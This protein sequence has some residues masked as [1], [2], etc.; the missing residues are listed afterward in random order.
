[1]KKKS[2]VLHLRK[3]KV[4][5]FHSIYGGATSPCNSPSQGTTD[6]DTNP[7]SMA[8]KG[9]SGSGKNDEPQNTDTE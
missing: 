6:L 2:I 1:M 8:I 4:A 7:T 9:C 5:N 3:S